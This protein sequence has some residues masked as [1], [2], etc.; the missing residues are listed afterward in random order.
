MSL[1]PSIKK[2]DHGGWR[3]PDRN[4][5]SFYCLIPKNASSWISSVLSYNEWIE[6]TQETFPKQELDE[7]IVV[8]RDP[9]ERW[10]A[11]VAQY[12]IG[13][14]LNSHWFDRDKYSQ[15]Y[16]GSYIPGKVN[17]EGEFITGEQFVA[18][19]NEVIE[20]LLFEQIAFDDHTQEQHW[21]VNYFS[22]SNISWFYL[23]ENFESTFFNHF[24][25]HPLIAPPVPDFNRGKDNTDVKIITEF[26]HKRIQQRPY[27]KNCV[28]RYYSRDYKMIEQANFK[29]LL[30]ESVISGK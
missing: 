11:G 7:L 29:C 20:R 2:F 6:G 13:Y 3:H 10:V 21:Y 12:L 25:D 15:G 24:K 17:Y 1:I 16:Y 22:C 14:I 5:L 26:L 27:L 23:N 9:V 8:L 30:S 28:E 18:N 19:Y 4:Y